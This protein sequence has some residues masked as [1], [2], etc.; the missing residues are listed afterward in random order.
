[1]VEEC[2][3]TQNQ[4]KESVFKNTAALWDYIIKEQYLEN[5]SELEVHRL[6]NTI[7]HSRTNGRR[8]F[9]HSKPTVLES[10]LKIL[11]SR[12]TNGR[13]ICT[14]CTSLQMVEQSLNNTKEQKN[15]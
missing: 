10:V 6:M 3:C 7:L 8:V 11:L 5:A 2:L 1:M 13:T 9:V 15:Q 14:V 4:R 12:G